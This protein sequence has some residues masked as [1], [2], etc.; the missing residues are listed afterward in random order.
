MLM[1]DPTQWSQLLVLVALAGVYLVSTSS[2]SIDLQR[3][4]DALGAMNLLFL[5]FLL[6]GVGIR[7]AYPIVSLEGEG[8][9][10]LQTGPLRSSQIVLA[11]FFNA[12]PIMVL[13][14]G[15]LGFAGCTTYRC[16]SQ[17]GLRVADCGRQC[18]VWP[19]R[20]LGLAWA[21]PFPDSAPPTRLRSRCLREG[22]S[23]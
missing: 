7:T 18:R 23:T 8:F 19:S 3:F 4:R 17:P 1:R 22:L 9:W 12:L 21:P 14:G 5:S 13:L 6:A 20:E 10:L 2:I 11:K 16:L 15:G